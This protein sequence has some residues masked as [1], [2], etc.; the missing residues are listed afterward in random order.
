MI[1]AVSED[2]SVYGLDRGTGGVVWSHETEGRVGSLAA[3]VDGVL[4]VSSTDGTVR[5]LDAATGTLHWSIAVEGEPTMP[6]VINGRV[7]VGTTRGKIH[8]IGGTEV[9]P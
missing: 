2:N 3:L 6:A 1:Y 9:V 4:Y 7:F 5:A 8:A